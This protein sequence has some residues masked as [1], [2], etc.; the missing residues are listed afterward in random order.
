[1]S[2]P[3]PHDEFLRLH[4]LE[5][6]GILTSPPDPALDEIVRLAA[7]ICGCPV[8]GI[9]LLD[10]QKPVYKSL[11]GFPA[12]SLTGFPA[13]EPAQGTPPCLLP[14]LAD[15]ALDILEIHDALEHPEYA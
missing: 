10:S 6:Y 3:L 13:A 2:A 9:A 8:A 11:T 15:N 7:Q 12:K 14:L 4:A 1:M 5:Q